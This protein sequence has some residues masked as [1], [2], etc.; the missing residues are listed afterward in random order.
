MHAGA[1]SGRDGCLRDGP[2]DLPSLVH[3]EPRHQPRGAHR[4][5]LL[6]GI[7]TFGLFATDIFVNAGQVV[8]GNLAPHF[9]ALCRP[10]YTALG[11]QQLTQFISGEEACTGDPELVLRARKTFP[12]KEAALSVYAAVY[13]TVSVGLAALVPSG[14]QGRLPASEEPL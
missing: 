9:L 3:W 8:T 6:P 14:Q 1:V 5:R 2:W 7:Y 11:C 10:N 13:L 12:S 4:L